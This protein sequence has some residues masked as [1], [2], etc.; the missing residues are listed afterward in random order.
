MNTPALSQPS[1]P[2]GC[3]LRV[4]VA[5][6]N[7]DAADTLAFLVQ[8]WGHE[9]QVVYDGERAL[10]AAESFHPDAVLSDIGMPG[11]DGYSLARR[12]RAQTEFTQATLVAVTAYSDDD[13]RRLSKEAGFNHHLVKPV[14]PGL[15]HALLSS[16]AAV[17][18]MSRQTR[19]TA[20]RT[21]ELS[22]ELRQLA[23]ENMALLRE[24]RAEMRRALSDGE[25]E[26]IE[27]E[28]R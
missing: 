11:L 18:Q 17:L 23:S 25:S 27:S 28:K 5:D 4:L 8:M 20:R 9:V 7:R 16:L 13:A 2:E 6:D 12:L 19:E 26:Q 10:Q 3:Q 14:E 15:L 21:H 1:L 22:R 24:N